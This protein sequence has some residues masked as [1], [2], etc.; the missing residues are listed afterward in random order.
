[1]QDDPIAAAAGVVD[2]AVTG[3]RTATETAGPE[4][5]IGALVEC[6]RVSRR[7]EQLTVTLIASL[8]RD[9]E[10][11]ER[12]YRRPAL[13]VADLLGCDVAQATRWVKLAGELTPRIG[14]D[15]QVCPP[16]LAATAAMFA[17]G[18]I[19]LRHAE[20]ITAALGT[21]AAARL[22]P[23][24]WAMAEQTLAEHAPRYQPRE[25]ACFARDLISALDE[26]GP[27][28]D[29]RDPQQ[30]N[31]LHLHRDPAGGGGTITGRLDAP[32]FDAVAT[33]LDAKSKPQPEDD[34]TLPQ[35]H[36]DALGE[37]CRH[38]LGFDE[39]IP[40]C[41]GERPHVSVLIPLA[42]LETRARRALLDFGGAM[43]PADLRALACDARVVPI[44][45]GGAGQPLD[46]GRAMR[47]V[48]AHLRR[49][50]VARDR[51]CAWPGCDRTP[52]WCEVH[53]IREWEHHGETE[54]TNLVMLCAFHH[55]LLHRASQ[56]TV[57]IR[58]GLP[59]FIPPRW[60]DFDQ[61]PRRKPPPFAA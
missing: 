22:T 59:E 5:K 24:V 39:T 56:W 29:D 30:P 6:Q 45:L 37:V 41:G 47:T 1:M 17:T 46:V 57:R 48:P 10:F 13:A 42:D 25:L 49:A 15:G 55:R 23:A 43:S 36:A 28:P 31:A 14:L 34:R 9:G 16:R 18:K 19:G 26:D 11:T 40:S 20:T 53:H 12:G 44:V 8:E 61:A 52:S 4:A 33:V 50:V 35:R 54:I 7:L 38:A 2:T 27:A 58:S 21:R 3:L 51:G 32:T 60:I